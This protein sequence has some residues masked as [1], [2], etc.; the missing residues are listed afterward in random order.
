MLELAI[1]AAREAGAMLK[2][3][4][5]KAERIDRKAGEETNLVT[6]LDRRSEEM[7]IGRVKA[8][9]PEHEVLAEES[10]RDSKK[11]EYRWIIDPI[12]GTTNFAH[13]LP[14]FA[15]SIGIEF[16][17]TLVAGVVYDPT[18]DEMFT[19]EKGKGAFLNGDRISVSTTTRLI[20]SV[21]A[22]GFPYDI[23]SNSENIEHFRN[24]L[25][26]ARALRRL[27]SAAIDLCY[28]ACGRLDGYWE[29]SLNPWDMAAGVLL[30]E[31]AGG[32]FTD[33]D[34]RPGSIYSKTV[35]TSNGRIHDQMVEVLRK[36]RS[37][38]QRRK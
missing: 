18:R 26:E 28:V 22:T 32:K 35:L 8:E 25:F 16:Q 13:G 19:V 11:S 38:W 23:R 24:F 12:D 15:V 17:G 31:E 29:L 3:L 34:G 27:G 37:S 2:D 10:G 9:Y 14:I 7:I 4:A 1:K 21:V 33:L 30:V 36:G 20:E 6:E 5:G